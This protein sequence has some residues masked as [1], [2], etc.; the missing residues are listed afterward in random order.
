MF[1]SFTLKAINI[2]AQAR[3]LSTQMGLGSHKFRRIEPGLYKLIIHEAINNG[4]TVVESGQD[5]GVKA[6]AD[7]LSGYMGDTRIKVL[8]RLGYNV[9]ASS[10][11]QVDGT[12]LV[13][14][15]S[16]QQ[17]HQTFQVVHTLNRESIH[18]FL[19]ESPLVG[20][21]NPHLNIIPMIHNPEEHRGDTLT[22]LTDAFC[23]L[24]D[25][26]ADRKISSFGIVSNGLSLPNDHPLH[27]D[28]KG[29]VLEAARIAAENSSKL[30]SSLSI[31][32]LP[33]N[34]LESRGI[35]VAKAIKAYL[36]ESDAKGMPQGLEL[37][38]MRPLTC[39]P[40]LGTGN[41]QGFQLIDYHLP[42]EP[43]ITEWSNMMTN[44]PP[45]YQ[46]TYKMALSHFDASDLLEEAQ[47]RKLNA[48]EE[49]IL[50]GAKIIRDMLQTLDNS[51]ES[52]RSFS[53]H[54]QMLLNQVLPIMQ[55]TFD[56]IDEE[57][58]EVLQNY[59]ASV[60]LA[61]RYFI[62]RNT[63]NLLINGGHGVESYDIPSE[64]KLQEFALG[65]LIKADVFS[66]IIVGASKTEH[67]TETLE[68]FKKFEL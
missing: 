52:T 13:E 26:V 36:K 32:Q 66:Q 48:E 59:F 38:A 21:E 44:P 61:A 65:E 12:V 42:T 51:L 43:G 22:R 54:E 56:E 55:G 29:V 64:M 9:T 28:W 3:W 37:F 40:D 49:E 14:T 15:V 33:A 63:R 27:L 58:H 47:R 57:S 24:E 2:N 7:I 68:V 39:F 34:I 53:Q 35:K 10:E 18:N 16:T 6:L 8:S 25:A 17:G 45:V 67:V 19:N 20:L 4:I 60:G 46:A 23:E 31:I 41:N 62:A 11:N 1:T 5:E 50:Q 30:F